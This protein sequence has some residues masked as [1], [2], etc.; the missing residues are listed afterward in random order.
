M[1]N[2][3]KILAL[4]LCF[5]L[6]LSL[7][8]CGTG[9]VSTVSS[10]GTL[11]VTEGKVDPSA[12]D[13]A[14]DIDGL[15]SY[16]KDCEVITGEATDMSADFIGAVKGK[17]F[18]F[19]YGDATITVE[20]YEYDLDNINTNEKAKSCLESVKTAGKLDILGKTIE[21]RANAA[22]KFVMIYTCSAEGDVYTAF[23]ERVNNLFTAFEGK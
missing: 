16:M 9:T 17:Q 8:A 15:V 7:T 5:V 2:L 14:N 13:Y 4:L 20:F 1:K 21:A 19:T 6:V 22:G 12:A 3:K 18:C 11:V 23:T 10:T